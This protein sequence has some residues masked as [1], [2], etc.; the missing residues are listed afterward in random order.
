MP[1]VEARVIY[2]MLNQLRF[3]DGV[4]M[5]GKLDPWQRDLLA[6]RLLAGDGIT[7]GQLRKD[8]KIG[9]DVRISLEEAGKDGLDDYRA[10][11]GALIGKRVRGKMVQD[12]FGANPSYSP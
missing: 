7:F 3:G 10:R 4:N 9:P 2:E 12:Y 6:S 11:S 1:S 8:L 5:N